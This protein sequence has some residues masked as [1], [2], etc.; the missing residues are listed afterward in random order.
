[1]DDNN[2]I[3]EILVRYALRQKLT[4]EELAR[5]E[6]W[7]ARSEPHRILVDQFRNPRWVAEQ[8]RQLH[9]APTAEMWTDIRG[10]IEQGGAV[11]PE[12]ARVPVWRS[13]GWQGIGWGAA[14]VMLL[15]IGLWLSRPAGKQAAETA[16][17]STVL[18]PASREYTA[19]KE[20]GHSVHLPD[21]SITT[22]YKNSSV[23]YLGIGP[24]G[25]RV[26]ELNG[27]ASFDVAAIPGHPFILR[28]PNG[29][30][31]Q[32]LGTT[33][34]ARAYKGEN[35]NWLV[36]LSW[37][38]KVVNALNAAVVKA[39]EQ[40]RID[41]R[42]V[43]VSPVTDIAPLLAWQ[44]RDNRHRPIGLHNATLPE[45]LR[46]VASLYGVQVSNPRNIQGAAVSGSL[47]QNETL[48]NTLRSIEFMQGG[49]IK[50]YRAGDTVV[51]LP[52]E[53]K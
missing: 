11:V 38:V 19:G 34:D 42:G 32:V 23:R 1:M 31:G 36:V 15:A 40:A 44:E 24:D 21:G 6:E 3:I 4:Q 26:C 5:V 45:V 47:P 13:M 27:E 50:L 51:V 18:A 43:Q 35:E 37:A 22:L 46:I 52:G 14:M 7:R 53:S 20:A 28:F 16:V 33:F 12:P 30:Y 49:T 29:T 9:A 25:S 8:R 41:G 48:E 17:A 10:Y 2:L 39:N